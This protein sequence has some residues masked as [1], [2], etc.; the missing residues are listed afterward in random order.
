M[1]FYRKLTIAIYDLPI[2][3]RYGSLFNRRLAYI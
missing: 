1:T 2:F 3:Y